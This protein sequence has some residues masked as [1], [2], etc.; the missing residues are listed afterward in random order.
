PRRML[1][2]MPQP[3]SGPTSSVRKIRRSRIPWSS[4]AC[5]RPEV[6]RGMPRY[7][8]ICCRMSRYEVK[9]LC[10]R[11]MTAYFVDSGK[12]RGHRPRL[13]RAQERDEV[14]LLLVRQIEAETSVVE[15]ENI[16]QRCR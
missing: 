9:R 13:Q 6:L 4:S 8:T 10:C 5:S 7:S 14:R 12:A 1:F 3:W 11:S 16:Q 2:E 15:V